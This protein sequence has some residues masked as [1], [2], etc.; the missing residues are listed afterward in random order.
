MDWTAD[1][2]T[3]VLR[4]E[5]PPPMEAPYHWY[6]PGDE[7]YVFDQLHFHWGA[8][9]LVGSEHTLNNERFPLEMHVVHHR[10]DLNNL[11]NASLY[12]GG[13]RVVAFFF[14]VSQMGHCSV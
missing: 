12:L 6:L 5:W 14:R 4:A 3:V 8:E 2:L 13:I 1:D 11:E 9:D 10:R 7:E